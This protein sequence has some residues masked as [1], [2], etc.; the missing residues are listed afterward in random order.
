LAYK[1]ANIGATD[2]RLGNFQEAD[3][4]MSDAIKLF[5][6]EYGIILNVMQGK[7]SIPVFAARVKLMEIKLHDPNII[8]LKRTLLKILKDYRFL[9]N[10]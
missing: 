6:V 8:E 10:E 5:E 7:I 3:R 4:N 1:F 2:L 9:P